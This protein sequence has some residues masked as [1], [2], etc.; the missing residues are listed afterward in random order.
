MEMGMR[1]GSPWL[2]GRG[3][4]SSLQEKVTL[5]QYAQLTLQVKNNQ[6][7]GLGGRGGCVEKVLSSCYLPI[8]SLEGRNVS[9]D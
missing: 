4:A 2:G 1:E 3:Q 7:K 8:R 9:K 6:G 5:A